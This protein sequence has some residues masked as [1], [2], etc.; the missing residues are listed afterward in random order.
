MHSIRFGT[1]GWRGIIAEDFTFA[2][3]RI[4]ATPSPATS[5]VAKMHA[6]ACWSAMT[7]ACV[8]H[9]RRR[10]R[11]TIKRHRHASLAS[12]QTLPH[13]RDF[14]AG[15]PAQRCRR[16]CHHREPQSLFLERNQVQSQL[17]QQRFAVHRR[18]N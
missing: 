1:D 10:C 2:N 18:A 12:R 4:V 8:R 7:I 17:R 5:C 13:T 15:P 11:Q 16:H 9:H 6:R 3:A 14:P